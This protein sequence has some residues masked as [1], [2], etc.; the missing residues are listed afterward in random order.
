M[1][2]K[3]QKIMIR[4]KRISYSENKHILNYYYYYFI[5]LLGG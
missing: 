2:T 3:Q 5:F 4:R 1:L